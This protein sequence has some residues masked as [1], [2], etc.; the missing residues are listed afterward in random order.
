[1]VEFARRVNPTL[2]ILQVSAQSGDGLEAWYGWLDNLIE[3]R[4][5]AAS[6]ES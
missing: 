5:A 6:V 2:E 4:A 3:R 1:L